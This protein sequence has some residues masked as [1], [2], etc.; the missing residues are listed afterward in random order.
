MF[1]KENTLKANASLYLQA[2]SKIICQ[3][4]NVICSLSFY[5]N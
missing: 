1:R 3:K 2:T 5:K 4:K